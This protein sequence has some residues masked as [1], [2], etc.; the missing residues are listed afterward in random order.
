M[1][2]KQAWTNGPMKVIFNRPIEHSITMKCKYCNENSEE[3]DIC[4]PCEQKL[5]LIGWSK[6]YE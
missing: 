2:Q 6:E 1:K 5:A 4:E 3:F